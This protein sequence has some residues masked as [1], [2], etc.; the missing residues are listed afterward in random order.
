MKKILGISLMVLLAAGVSF[1]SNITMTTKVQA[2]WEMDMVT[3]TATAAYV[4][5]GGGIGN[6][7][8]NN[9]GDTR[10]VFNLTGSTGDVS[11]ESVWWITNSTTSSPGA[12][13]D[14]ADATWKIGGGPFYLEVV[15]GG[16]DSDCN[17]GELLFGYNNN[18]FAAS[19]KANGGQMGG[20]QTNAA[21]FNKTITITDP[22]TGTTY[23]MVASNQ[24][25][26]VANMYWEGDESYTMGDFT[27]AAEEQYQTWTASAEP[28]TIT[29][30]SEIQLRGTAAYTHTFEG[31]A[32]VTAGAGIAYMMDMVTNVNTAAYP[33]AILSMADISFDKTIVPTATFDI[34]WNGGSFANSYG[35]AGFNTAS[36]S[37]AIY[38]GTLWNFTAANNREAIMM[39]TNGTMVSLPS[40]L[41]LSGRYHA[42]GYEPWATL[43][44]EFGPAADLNGDG[45]AGITNTNAMFIELDAGVD[46][47]PAAG[48]TLTPELV[49]WV[50]DFADAGKGI[51]NELNGPNSGLAN[52]MSLKLT[53]AYVIPTVV[54]DPANFAPA[55]KQ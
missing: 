34:K 46:I 33:I 54:I 14:K 7:D 16:Q 8:I 52:T 9:T 21:P 22:S 3:N 20:V 53:G 13:L 18:G 11:G 42:D 15:G 25:P 27:F 26:M 2:G 51:E 24:T 45:M 35:D 23:T 10:I 50:S 6:T 39:N 28:C 38:A 30:S 32:V 12:G 4:N 17:G 48:F 43:N 31:T 41:A 44:F 47:M 1:A 36:S 40:I 29:N 55:A 49:Y 37:G 19:I 5:N